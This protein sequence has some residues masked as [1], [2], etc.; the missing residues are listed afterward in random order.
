MLLQTVSRCNLTPICWH[1]KQAQVG[2]YT[3]HIGIVAHGHNWEAAN[4]LTG[5]EIRLLHPGAILSPGTSFGP[6]PNSGPIGPISGRYDRM[7]PN[8]AHGQKIFWGNFD[9]A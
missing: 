8:R 6:G 1:Y 9:A 2:A 3:F 4:R 7:G 5:G